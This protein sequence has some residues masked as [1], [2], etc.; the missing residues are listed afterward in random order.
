[1][2]GPRRLRKLPPPAKKG[3]KEAICALSRHM[4]VCVYAYIHTSENIL[5]ESIR[6]RGG[7]RRGRRGAKAMNEVSRHIVSLV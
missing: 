1:M 3:K 2:F 4:Y 7:R 5:W 6:G